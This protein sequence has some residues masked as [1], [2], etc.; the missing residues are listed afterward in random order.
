MTSLYHSPISPEQ[1]NLHRNQLVTPAG[2]ASNLIRHA[3]LHAGTPGPKVNRAAYEIVLL[4]HRVLG[5][6]PSDPRTTNMDRSRSL[7]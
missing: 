2:V 5:L 1:V 7:H 4:A 3:A 6:D